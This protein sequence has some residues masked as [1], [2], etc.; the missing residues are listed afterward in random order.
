M[1][2][3]FE[4]VVQEGKAEGIMPAYSEWDGEPIH[5]SRRLLT[6]LLRTKWGFTGQVVSDYGAVKMLNSFQRVAP[7][8]LTAGKMALTA[9]VDVEAPQVYGFGNDLL[10][11]VERGEGDPA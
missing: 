2:V 10:A 7:D 5:A 11:A 6:D 1:S 4:K 3:P 9:G 8:A